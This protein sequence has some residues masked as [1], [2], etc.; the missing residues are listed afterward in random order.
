MT[1]HS[2]K[3]VHIFELTKLRYMNNLIT[4]R[5]QS[6]QEVTNVPKS[7]STAAK[8]LKRLKQA[9]T[10]WCLNS[11]MCMQYASIA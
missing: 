1:M 11:G 9:M 10:N 2:S 3:E 4:T 6:A 7:T 5:K 8:A